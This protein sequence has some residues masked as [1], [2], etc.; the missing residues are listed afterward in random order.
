M[1][2]REAIDRIRSMSDE[3]MGWELMCWRMK[4]YAKFNGIESNYPDTQEKIYNWLL[5]P[6]EGEQHETN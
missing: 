2:G 5:T 4:T 6:A 1:T 3:E